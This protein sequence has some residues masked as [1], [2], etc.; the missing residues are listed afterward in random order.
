MSYQDPPVNP[1]DP[2]SQDFETQTLPLD[3]IIRRGIRAQML[4]L[5]VCLPCK[6]TAVLGNQ[7][8]NV[9]PTLQ[10]RY[11][12]QNVGTNMPAIQN[13]PVSMPMG[14]DYY[15]K[16]PV[17]VGDSG[18][19]V[20]SDRSLDVWLA[21]SGEIVDP[22]DSRQHHLSDAIFVPGLVP[23]SK[24]TKDATTD[25][26]VKNGSSEFRVQ[27]NGKFQIKNQNQ[28]LIDLM[29]QL[30]DVLLNKTFTLT[31]FGPQPFIDFTI[32]LLQQIRTKLQTL[33][34]P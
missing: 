2:G 34:G 24:Q 14:A 28:E 33:K 8:V 25:L 10:V 26:V 23:F 17:A 4:N 18:H 27:K 16:L 1:Y 22:Q 29:D 3:E 11:I 12:D 15:I 5:K 19:I 30:L 31:I 6:V 13:V 9:Q 32:Q 21:G 7:K 20:C